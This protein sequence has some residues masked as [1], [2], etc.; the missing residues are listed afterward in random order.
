MSS[1]E[2]MGNDSELDAV[3]AEYLQKQEAGE[4]PDQ[5]QYISAYPHL[6]EGLRLFFQ[7]SERLQPLAWN[8][9][10]MVPAGGVAGGWQ[11]SA[12]D[13]IDGRYRLIEVLGEG[14]MGTVWLAEQQRPVQRRVAIKLIRPGLDSRQVLA[15]FEAERQALAM[16][17]HPNIARVFDGGLTSQGRPYFV[18]EYLRGVPLLEYCDR[19][20]LSVPDRLLLF[21]AVCRGV[22]HAHLK[23]IVHRDLKP[24]NVLVCEYD[25][26]AI[27]RVIDFGLAKALHQPLTELTLHTA[28]GALVGTP[29]YMSPEQS[30]FN[31]LDVDTRTDVYSLGVVLYELLT[32]HTPLEREAL[33][34]AAFLEMLRLIREEE[35]LA[36]S[37]RLS[38]SEQLATA[39]LRRRTEPRLLC[40]SLSGELDWIVLKSLEKQRDRRY[41]T[42]Q[43]LAGDIERFL[44]D[45]PVEAAPPSKL[46][47]LR[48]VVR[49]HRGRFIAAT[50]LLLAVFAGLTGLMQG[51]LQ[52]RESAARLSALVQKTRTQYELR[53]RALQSA[54]EQER[55]AEET[56]SDGIYLVLGDPNA[57]RSEPLA[58]LSAA[59]C[60]ALERWAAVADDEMSVRVLA[61][62]LRDA[63]RAV[64]VASRMSHVLRICPG[65]SG[66][67]REQVLKMLADRQRCVECAPEVRAVSCL[68]TLTIGGSELP[69]LRECLTVMDEDSILHRFLEKQI[70]RR[71]SDIPEES[72]QECCR[73]LVGATALLRERSGLSGDVFEQ[74]IPY[75]LGE[76]RGGP[77]EFECAADMWTEAEPE[78]LDHL[79]EG[80]VKQIWDSVI[81]GGQTTK[82]SVDLQPAVQAACREAPLL[83]FALL[84]R[85]S[86]EDFC[87]VLPDVMAAGVADRLVPWAAPAESFVSLLRSRLGPGEIRALAGRLQISLEGN[88]D[89]GLLTALEAAEQ[90][91]R[92]LLSVEIQNLLDAVPY[93]TDPDWEK[94]WVSLRSRRLQEQ[95]SIIEQHDAWQIPVSQSTNAESLSAAGPVATPWQRLDAA[96]ELLGRLAFRVPES[97]SLTAGGSGVVQFAVAGCVPHL[98]CADIVLTLPLLTCSQ[99]LVTEAAARLAK[100]VIPLLPRW[101]QARMRNLLLSGLRHTPLTRYPQKWEDTDANWFS[102]N[103]TGSAEL[104]AALAIAGN[105][106]FDSQ[107]LAELVQL[108][109]EPDKFAGMAF[110]LEPSLRILSSRADGPVILQ[111][112]QALLSTVCGLRSLQSEGP[113]PSA[114]L[115]LS[116]VNSWHRDRVRMSRITDVDTQMA[117]QLLL[118]VGQHLEGP[119]AVLAW[120]DAI[121][122]TT[123][124]PAAEST[125]APHQQLLATTLRRSITVLAGRLPAADAPGHF[126]ELALFHSVYQKD[127][128][129]SDLQAFDD[130]ALPLLQLL[131]ESDELDLAKWLVEPANVL[132]P[133]VCSLA[134][135]PLL[136]RMRAEP[137]AKLWDGLWQ[138][139]IMSSEVVVKSN[140]GRSLLLEVFSILSRRLTEVQCQERWDL[141]IRQIEQSRDSQQ[142]AVLTGVLW[143]LSDRVQGRRPGAAVP[144]L[145]RCVT[146]S[147]ETPLQSEAGVFRQS[148]SASARRVH[149]HVIG[150]A[151]HL[152]ARSRRLLAA[153]CL[154]AMVRSPAVRDVWTPVGWPTIAEHLCDDPR[155]IL[156][157]AMHPLCSEWLSELLLRRFEELVLHDGRWVFFVSRPSNDSRYFGTELRGPTSGSFS[158][159]PQVRQQLEAAPYSPNAVKNPVKIA[160]ADE[161]TMQIA[162]ESARQH[163]RITRVRV[164]RRLRTPED[165]R[166]WMQQN[167]P[168]FWQQFH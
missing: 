53:E 42:T 31:N 138:R 30:Q 40:R 13:E 66:V 86:V 150:L 80:R 166:T 98:D 115:T 78:V 110:A 101:Q 87:S 82:N 111:A 131:T 33:Q 84:R 125:G 56:L 15:R 38:T 128:Y 159:L 92:P 85:V 129:A 130:A 168:E 89:P 73:A 118:S 24:S 148:V 48:R 65:L 11:Y 10:T 96:K 23:G 2:A 3:I 37:T 155:Q 46:R 147:V 134:L 64:R 167:R 99:S 113:E 12:G 77:F 17:D 26:A 55:L 19:K 90:S 120:Q 8:A 1:A 76:R 102:R 35:V 142:D 7:G 60:G 5:M 59:E 133:A 9:A 165:V 6:A 164:P 136:W 88:T 109:K 72:L 123:A 25:G 119:D 151:A 28:H 158:A 51:W 49:R 141:V 100:P 43:A 62:G 112:W 69:A 140:P 47:W 74:L 124:D 114:G 70:Y 41:Q 97:L 94:R 163:A 160:V 58:G 108:P 91:I 67:R 29:V 52:S 152:D 27:P 146:R 117:S 71:L 14:G 54:R 63:D 68:L 149:D 22:Q 107:L 18:M 156:D 95:F 144:L 36:P 157:A 105:G 79:T 139:Q 75:E 161:R 44:A 126:R 153:G 39:A 20:Q 81:A 116:E 57:A 104:L 21:T 34:N 4:H 93:S 135:R 137:A 61:D 103:L 145:V 45:E 127:G 106:A 16:M 121:Q 132:D 154:D 32:G 83:M 50:V 143:C 162:S 122:R